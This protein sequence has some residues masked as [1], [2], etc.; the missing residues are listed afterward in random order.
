MLTYDME[1]RGDEPLYIYLYIRIKADIMG[2][3]IRPNEKLPS[4]RNLAEHLK[5]SVMTVQNAYLQ[6]L[7]EGYITSRCKDRKSVV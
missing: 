7:S 1:S 6:L 5:V 2:G 3:V 4:K